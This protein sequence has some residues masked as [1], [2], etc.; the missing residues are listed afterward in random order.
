MSLMDTL[1]ADLLKA[2][3][4]K[5]DT[6]AIGLLTALVGEAT[7]IGKDNGNRETT[8]AEAQKVVKKF[9]DGA[10][11]TL[12]ILDKRAT[13]PADLDEQRTQVEREIV[14][15]SAYQPKQLS[16]AELRE[17]IVQFK[18]S[19]PDAKIGQYMGHL[20]QTLEAGTY[21]GGEANKIV[22]EVIG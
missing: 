18:A 22:K 12:D 6:T 17:V 11:Q 4:A 13:G 7:R 3:K 19:N 20:K 1:R 2:R 16:S 14:I 9:L 8:D 21:D 15:L 10:V 5:T